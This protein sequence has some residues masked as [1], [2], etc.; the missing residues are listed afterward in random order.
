MVMTRNE[1]RTIANLM[2][3]KL[4]YLGFLIVFLFVHSIDNFHPIQINTWQFMQRIQHGYTILHPIQLISD[5]VTVVIALLSSSSETIM[6]L[7]VGYPVPFEQTIRKW[8]LT[9]LLIRAESIRI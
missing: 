1:M 5:S 9:E 4:S 6:H 8:K 3:N 7:H 2:Y